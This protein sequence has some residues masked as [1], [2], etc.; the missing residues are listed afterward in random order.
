MKYKTWST[1]HTDEDIL[2][3]ETNVQELNGLQGTQSMSELRL[4]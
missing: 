1:W 3:K 4:N 2:Q